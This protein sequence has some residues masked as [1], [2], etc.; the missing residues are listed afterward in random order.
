[1]TETGKA[2]IIGGTPEPIGGVT[3]MV[4]RLC[5]YFSEDIAVLYDLYPRS[6][7]WA[8]GSVSHE[9]R[10][11][12]KFRTLVWLWRRRERIATSKVYFHFSRTR[13]LLLLAVLRK[14]RGTMWIVTL[15][16]GELEAPA[17][18]GRF[19]QRL[20]TRIVAP[21][22]DRFGV[23]GEKQ[24]KFYESCGIG[25]NRRIAITPYLPYVDP[26]A[27]HRP[28][29]GA[30][31]ERLLSFKGDRDLIAA[32]GY[33]TALYRH[34]WVVNYLN[35]TKHDVCVAICLYGPNRSEMVRRLNEMCTRP[36]RLLLFE[37]LSPDEFQEVLKRSTLYVRPTE[38]DSFGIAVAEALALGKTVVASDACP[39]PDGAFLFDKSSK[40][41]FFEVLDT[42]ISDRK[43][44]SDYSDDNIERIRTLL[45]IR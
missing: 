4:Y 14:R 12:G 43:V 7:K 32:S 8:P 20:L 38:T 39:R 42:A 33:A 11:V 24:D 15:H 23:I 25:A 41:A 35:T 34:D 27:E 22:I 16:H 26:P 6:I 2:I 28:D 44:L 18:P 45:D 5:H 13:G 3:T 37:G 40:V 21:K 10:P 36:D 29:L 31:R 1:M 9:V 19:F 30:L 17:N